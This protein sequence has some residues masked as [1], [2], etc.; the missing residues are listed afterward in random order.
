MTQWSASSPFTTT[1]PR[2]RSPSISTPRYWAFC[3]GRAAWRSISLYLA[4][5]DRYL[6]GL[7]NHFRGNLDNRDPALVDSLAPQGAAGMRGW[8]PLSSK[9]SGSRRTVSQEE[10]PLSV[11]RSVIVKPG[12]GRRERAA[13]VCAVQGS[14]RSHHVSHPRSA[15]RR[16]LHLGDLR[17][18]PAAAGGRHRAP[19]LPGQRRQRPHDP[20]ALMAVSAKGPSAPCGTSGRQGAQPL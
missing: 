6:P 14:G 8:R 12:S 3:V 18:W 4:P 2:R 7:L 17:P 13:R 16:G 20:A 11:L 5:A 15:V 1:R 10:Y 19:G 9:R